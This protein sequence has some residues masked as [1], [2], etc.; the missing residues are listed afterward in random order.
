MSSPRRV[1]PTRPRPPAATARAAGVAAGA[2]RVGPYLF[3]AADLGP[4]G[5]ADAL[6]ALALDVRARL[7]EA[8]PAVVLIAGAAGDRPV[9]VIATNGA[10]RDHGAAAGD[11]VRI[12]APVLGGGG[13]GRPD[14]AQG[15]GTDV[16]AL[17]DAMAAVARE[18]GA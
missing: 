10:A 15:G 3:A 5:G 9:V 16:A 11:L 1:R 14:L 13:G 7:G 17:P 4:A 12:A 8:E 18:L 6:R 2:K